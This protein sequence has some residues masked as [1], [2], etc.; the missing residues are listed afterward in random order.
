MS[1][2][3]T[4][5]TIYK[6]IV[7]LQTTNLPNFVVLTG[8]NGSGKTHLL[9][10]IDEG[11]VASSIASNHAIDVALFNWDSIIPKDTGLFDSNQHRTQR[12]NW[13]QNIRSQQDKF[14]KNTQQQLI[15]LGIPPEHCTSFRKI[16]G[17]DH[18]SLQNVLPAGSNLQQ[19]NGQVDQILKNTA[20]NIFS[21]S[22]RSI[23]DQD[24]KKAA[25]KILQSDPSLFFETS[26]TRFFNHSDLLWGEVDPFQQAF[27][28]LFSN[29]RELIHRNDRLEKYPPEDE[30]EIAFLADEQFKLQY[31]E[32]PW[33]FV[34]K[35]LEVCNLDFRVD[36]PPLHE[37]GA[38]EPK[39]KKQSKDVD[40]RFTDLSSGEKVLMS[41]ALCLYNA[42]E[43]R[44]EKVFPKLLLLDEVDAPLHPSMIL[45]LLRTIQNVLVE[46]KNVSVIMTTHNSSTVALAP[47][48]ALYE[49]NP[50][51]PSVEKITQSRGV[52][53]LTTGVPTLSISFDGRRQVFVESKTDAV[54]YEKLYQSIKQDLDSERSLTFVEVGRKDDAGSEQ[55]AGCDQVK[56]IVESL[57]NNGNISV[58]GLID[59]DGSRQPSDR[60]HVLSENI[61]DGIENLILDPCLLTATV[62]KEN[63][64]FCVD[65]G[66]IADS[67]RYTDL[68]SWDQQKWA[69]VVGK[70]QAI[71]LGDTFSSDSA[72][73]I[74][75]SYK[76]GNTLSIAKD[77]LHLDDHS[78]ESK[79]I[80]VF[81]FLAPKNQNAGG[82]L[83][84]IIGS[85]L[86]DYPD[87]LP[88]DLI[89]TFNSLLDV[90]P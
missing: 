2:A 88:S 32:P 54:L 59:W 21:Q 29:Y 80:E 73:K 38:Y 18:I 20:Q 72:S 22:S 36:P 58:F 82:L 79:V 12:S 53:I 67:E 81:G 25:P 68:S 44:Q 45:S 89:D 3:L 55:N 19:I 15:G 42:N 37:T 33:E 40:M 62:L 90:D 24:W 85:V 74:E 13:F 65:R 48:S 34:N 63:H 43:T 70:L 56:R 61:R 30:T 23:G 51:G 10:A 17:I 31:G 87:L 39:L 60:I 41:F 50:D 8:L 52:S 78:L 49:M 69:E 47:E 28:R 4:F 26:E 16:R 6:S 7:G 76:N 57:S 46:E 35:I 84:H 66:L 5:T 9:E 14:L 75:V 77:Y 11:A 1:H 83:N 71:V 86:G 64:R 27:G